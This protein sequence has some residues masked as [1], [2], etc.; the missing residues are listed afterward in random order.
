MSLYFFDCED[1]GKVFSDDVGS[2]LNNDEKAESEAT[3]I[4]FELMRTS[5][6][7]DKRSIKIRVRDV[8]GRIL[9]RAGLIFRG[10]RTS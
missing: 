6:N 3:Q 9:Y 2:E 8:A 1:N 4:L 5:K 7:I 10:F